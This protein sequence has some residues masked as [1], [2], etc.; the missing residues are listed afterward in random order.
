M[1]YAQIRGG[2]V[3]NC[4]VLDDASMESVFAAGFDKLV[5]IDNRDESVSIGHAYNAGSDSFA[6][7]VVAAP[8]TRPDDR[9]LVRTMN[10]SQVSKEEWFAVD[11]GNGAYS[12]KAREIAYTYKNSKLIKTVEKLFYSDGSVAATTTYD[13]YTDGSGKT[14]V[15]RT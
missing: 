13:Y 9:Y 12:S 4:I 14:I 5:R 7:V 6:P 10:G 15:K 2:V 1:I 3:Q 8:K 11:G